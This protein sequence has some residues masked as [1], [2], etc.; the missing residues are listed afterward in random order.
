MPS[1]QGQAP[2]NDIKDVWAWVCASS[3]GVLTALAQGATWIEP[4]GLVWLLGFA[5][6][7]L[8]V[9][10]LPSE[11]LRQSGAKLMLGWVIAATGSTPLVTSH[12]APA[13]M[14]VPL[15]ALWLGYAG[16]AI[17]AASVQGQAFFSRFLNKGKAA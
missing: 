6:A 13:F 11:G 3:M 8:G 7:A 1:R 9:A 14:T 4:N 15:A 10:M 17:F 16:P 12:Y 5:G 2:V